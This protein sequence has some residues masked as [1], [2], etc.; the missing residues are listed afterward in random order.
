MYSASSRGS[1]V[2]NADGSR[3]VHCYSCHQF[4]MKTYLRVDRALCA[5]CELVLSGKE[6]P[7]NVLREY[8][9]SKA[10]KTDVSMLL[11]DDVPP[12]E[13]K[14]KFSLRSMGAGIMRALGVA[15]PPA[16]TPES[17]TIS[18]QKRRPR[19]FENVDL[20]EPADMKAVD[21][22]ISKGKKG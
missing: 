3:N 4:I 15:K 21:A 19:L 1:N 7:E 18:R 2:V 8:M 22:A 9:M 16:P 11:V 12:K 10:D 13:F 20:D 6:V 14:A 17:V 5:M